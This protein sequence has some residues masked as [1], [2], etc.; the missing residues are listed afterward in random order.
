MIKNCEW[1][2]VDF[3]ANVSYQISCGSVCRTEATKSI[4]NDENFCVT[5]IGDK[6][7]FNKFIRGLF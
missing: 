1:C 7:G 3:E 6:K 5:C 4:Y 2:G